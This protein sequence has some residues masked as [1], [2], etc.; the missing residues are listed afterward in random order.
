MAYRKTRR[1]R[2]RGRSGKSILIFVMLSCL[3]IGTVVGFLTRSQYVPSL[4]SWL[5]GN[6]SGIIPEETLSSFSRDELEGEV[7]RLNREISERDKN[8]DELRIELKLVSQ[9]SSSGRKR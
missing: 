3:L 7:K 8:I 2:R 9:G 1:K 5:R 6:P 4:S